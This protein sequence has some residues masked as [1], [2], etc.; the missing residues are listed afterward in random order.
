M[1]NSVLSYNVLTFGNLQ[2]GEDSPSARDL[3]THLMLV[4]LDCTDRHTH[5][6]VWDARYAL[7]L[8][9]GRHDTGFHTRFRI[10]ILDRK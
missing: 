3:R 1:F 6:G 10:S 4:D 2:E 5:E 7:W 9:S 8:S